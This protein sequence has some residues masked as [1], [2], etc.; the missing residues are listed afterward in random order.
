MNTRNLGVKIAELENEI[1]KLKMAT[2]FMLCITEVHGADNWDTFKDMTL[3]EIVDTCVRN[4][5]K[6]T[7]EVSEE[8][9]N[10]LLDNY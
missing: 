6:M 10:D 3:E 2:N 1:R 5:I 7:F 8:K 4:G 9:R